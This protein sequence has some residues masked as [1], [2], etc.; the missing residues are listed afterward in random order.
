MDFYRWIWFLTLVLLITALAGWIP[1][2]Y[3]V[4]TVS[5]V[6]MVY[7]FI[8]DKSLLAFPTQVRVV[9]FIFTL[10]GFWPLG[11]FYFFLLLLAGTIMVTFFGKCSIAFILKKMPWNRN[12]EIRLN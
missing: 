7:F 4:I 11:R 6:H 5:L 12:R 10:S 8:R 1:G 9:Y 2:Y 3:L